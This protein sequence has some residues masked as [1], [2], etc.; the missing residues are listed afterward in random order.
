MTPAGQ[1]IDQ[2]ETGTEDGLEM[3]E[4]QEIVDQEG[5][6]RPDS[7]LNKANGLEVNSEREENLH[8]VKVEDNFDQAKIGGSFDFDQIEGSF[9]F[10]KIV[11][12]FDSVKFVNS[13][14]F[15]NSAVVKIVENFD[16]VRSFRQG[17]DFVFDT[18]DS[19]HRIGYGLENGSFAVG[20]LGRD[21]VSVQVPRSLDSW[22]V[23]VASADTCVWGFESWC[24]AVH[25]ALSIGSE[26]VLSGAVQASAGDCL[27]VKA[28]VTARWGGWEKVSLL[29]VTGEGWWRRADL[30]R[31]QELDFDLEIVFW[32]SLVASTCPLL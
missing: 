13:F 7:D 15:D 19:D 18:F 11:D 24:S 22:L 28:L 12:N 4:M 17:F 25:F 23:L 6:K 10:L 3:I 5:M 1:N 29:Q 31:V 26:L 27:S 8:C 9:D 14:D 32:S 20:A 2:K 21:W 30:M 16:S